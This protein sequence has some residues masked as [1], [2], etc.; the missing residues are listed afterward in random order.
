MVG[1]TGQQGTQHLLK[2]DDSI[3]HYCLSG[4]VHIRMQTGVHHKFLDS[5][6]YFVVTMVDN[7]EGVQRLS[8]ETDIGT[9]AHPGTEVIQVTGGVGAR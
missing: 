2:P 4:A 5:H 9:T 3:E 6:R 7:E 1:I 8:D